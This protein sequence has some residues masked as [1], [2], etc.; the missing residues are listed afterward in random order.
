VTVLRRNLE[1]KARCP[2]PAAA[3]AAALALGAAPAARERQR[4]TFFHVRHGRLKLREI[5]R[6][7]GG[8]VPADMSEAPARAAELI[9]YRRADDPEVRASSYRLVAV[10]DPA[11]LRAALADAC[12]VRGEVVK[13]REIL[14]WH[15]VRI[16]LDEVEGLGRYLE[17]EAVMHPGRSDAEAE[18]RL[19]TL[20]AAL[21]VAPED[22]VAGAYADLLGLA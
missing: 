14:L 19:A 7:P 16:H 17:F 21:R 9:S 8:H 5:E 10:P 3:R 6:W 13:V 15:E 12:G 22:R 2:D 20:R 4:D 11:A 18:D 1:L